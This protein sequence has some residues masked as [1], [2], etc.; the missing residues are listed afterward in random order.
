MATRN[1]GRSFVSFNTTD[2]LCVHLNKYRDNLQGP[3][4][5]DFQ[6]QCEM[7]TTEDN[8]EPDEEHDEEDD[9]I[10]D[11][12]PD[13]PQTVYKGLFNSCFFPLKFAQHD[14]PFN[15]LQWLSVC[16]YVCSLGIYICPSIYVHMS[17]T[18]NHSHANH[19]LA[20]LNS[21]YSFYRHTKNM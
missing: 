3:L 9:D 16:M 14:D 6:I 17:T 19:V 1:K 11:D 12:Q 5:Q 21:V 2:E 18:R 8:D 13:L 4:A 7:P 10:V 15:P 20:R